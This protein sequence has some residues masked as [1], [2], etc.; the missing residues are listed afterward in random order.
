M[1]GV[2]GSNGERRRWERLNV[3]IP[4]FVRGTDT[5]GEAF[6]EFTSA[7]N[8]SAGGALIVMR[9][10]A[11]SPQASVSLEVPSAPWPQAGSARRRFDGQLIRMRAE[12]GCSLAAFRFTRPLLESNQKKLKV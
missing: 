8:V 10:L 11:V 9:N 5:K 2:S 12:G 4:I 6:I 3:A 7:L 1:P